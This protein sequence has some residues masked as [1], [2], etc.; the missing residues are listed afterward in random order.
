MDNFEAYSFL[1]ADTFL[2]STALPAKAIMVFPLM[3]IFG[4]YD[5]NLAVLVAV[6]AAF[7]A[8][9]ANY[10]IGRLIFTAIKY[11]PEGQV[12]LKIFSFFQNKGFLLLLLSWFPVFGAILTVFIG[13]TGTRAKAA[14]PTVLLVN[15]LYY[16]LQIS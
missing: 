9:L 11:K 16:S 8:A 4:T 3:K 6:I 13:F 2:S 1:F 14:I 7:I 10:G 12:P 5:M 15:V